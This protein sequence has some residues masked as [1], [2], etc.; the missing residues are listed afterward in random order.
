MDLTDAKAF[1]NLVT[2]EYKRRADLLPEDER[3]RVTFVLP[4]CRKARS[5]SLFQ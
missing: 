5:R 1:I 3:I 2:A 4:P